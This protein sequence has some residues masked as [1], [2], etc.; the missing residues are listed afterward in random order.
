MLKTLRHISLF[1]E[2]TEDQLQCLP[3]GIDVWLNPGEMLFNQGDPPEYFY[4]VFKGAVQISREVGNQ[5]LVLATYDTGTFFGEV[6]LLA[7]TLHLASGQAVDRSHVY[8]LEEEDF[9]Q[10]L[11]ICPSLRKEVL[12]YMANRMQELQMLS[13]QR[14]K[15]ISLGTLAAGLAHELNN[16]ASAA[17]R[18]T[19]QLRTTLENLESLGL[20]L[21]EHDLTLAQQKRL[22]ELQG[23]GI[24]H[25]IT[26]NQ[27]DPLT[28][29]DQEEQLTDWLESNGI[30]D[31]WK[32]APT[33]VSAGLNIEQLESIGVPVFANTFSEALTWLEA[34]LA[35]TSLLNELDQSTTR[36]SELIQAIK[37]YSFMDQAPLQE[38]DIHEG[39]DNTLIILGHKLKKHSIT[40]V[41]E[42]ALDLP[43]LQA[44]GSELNQVWTNLIDNAIDAIGKEGTIWLRTS[45]EK[46]Y[47]VVEI[48]DNGPGIPPEIQSRI[49]EPFFTTKAVGLGTGLGLEIAYRIVVNQHHGD[50][51]CFSQPGDTRFQ[52]RLPLL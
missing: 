47:V 11:T 22:L 33:L 43:R 48:A 28:Q 3:Q 49:F 50:I 4:I 23:N 16:P 41:R 9:W 20:R 8:C 18:S 52:I 40:V 19:E 27:L 35:G 42:Y 2:L 37:A 45:S 39:L 6:P 26:P 10:M 17:R 25:T 5:E 1:K 36:I 30:A 46:D 12:G 31:G 34:T 14:E 38:I 29:S 51:R 32:L 13:Q 24:E 44:H 7:G 21:V 15:L